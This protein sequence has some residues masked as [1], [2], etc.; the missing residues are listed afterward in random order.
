[1]GQGERPR[2]S[3]LLAALVLSSQQLKYNE[4]DLSPI[5]IKW[6]TQTHRSGPFEDLFPPRTI[7]IW[8]LRMNLFIFR[9][10]PR[11]CVVIVNSC[12]F[13]AALAVGHERRERLEYMK[14]SAI[15]HLLEASAATLHQHVLRLAGGKGQRC[16]NCLLQFNYFGLAQH[17]GYHFCIFLLNFCTIK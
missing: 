9:R 2:A 3:L 12:N 14:P 5:I 7:I 1:M 17:R 6:I 13:I 11:D 16:F 10:W 8:F 4:A 15:H